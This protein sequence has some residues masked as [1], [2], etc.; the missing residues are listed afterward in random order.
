MTDQKRAQ[1]S[2]ADGFPIELRGLATITQRVAPS[3]DNRYV[4]EAAMKGD[5]LA[6]RLLD[7]SVT[8]LRVVSCLAKTPQGRHVAKQLTRSGTASGAHYDEARGAE[9]RADFVHKIRIAA[10]EMRESHYWLRVIGRAGM[11]PKL[12]LSHAVSEAHQLVA[13]LT[14]SAKTAARK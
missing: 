8:V 3:P 5:D 4:E 1:L 6:D 9:S 12:D 2:I 7:F 10:K 11:A 14:A 13:I